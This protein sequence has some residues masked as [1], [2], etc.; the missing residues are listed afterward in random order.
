MEIEIELCLSFE[1]PSLSAPAAGKRRRSGGLQWTDQVA[2]LVEI[3]YSLA[4]KGSLNNGQATTKDV[5]FALGETFHIPLKNYWNTFA[6]I[7]NRKGDR[8]V[9]MRKL[10]DVLTL[11]MDQMDR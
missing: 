7:R 1:R 9:Y 11:K 5:V 6:A 4:A 8:A 10:H 3:A 2:D